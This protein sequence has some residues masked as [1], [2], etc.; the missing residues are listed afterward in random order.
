V[1]LVKHTFEDLRRCDKEGSLLV[2]L[3]THVAFISSGKIK[4][5][6]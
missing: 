1:D 2:Y 5:T 3:C 4:G 6:L